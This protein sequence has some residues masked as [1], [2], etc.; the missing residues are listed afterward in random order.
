MEPEG[1]VES[2]SLLR[3]FRWDGLG[4]WMSGQGEIRRAGVW[5]APLRY[6]P[7]GPLR[8]AL[9]VGPETPFVSQFLISDQLVLN[10][11]ELIRG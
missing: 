6:L 2:L 10:E 4:H 7:Y 8:P 5:V 11:I 3:V 1:N 9:G